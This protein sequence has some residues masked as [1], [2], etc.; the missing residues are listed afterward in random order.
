MIDTLGR[1]LDDYPGDPNRAC[2][3]N[4]VI[5]L[6]AKRMVRQF[7]VPKA[8]ADAALDEAEE[9]LRNLAEGIDIEELLAKGMQDEDEGDDDDD[10]DDDDDRTKDEMSAEERV[11]LDANTWPVRLLLVKVGSLALFGGVNS[12]GKDG[13]AS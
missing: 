1:L 12:N 7:D 8:G 13:I 5:A 11:A 9:E 2:C 10:D 3:F 4:H 6:V